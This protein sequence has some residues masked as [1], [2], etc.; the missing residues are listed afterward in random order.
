MSEGEKL[1]LDSGGCWKLQ[2]S[3]PGKNVHLPEHEVRDL[4]HKS[5][6]IFLSQPVLLEICGDIHGQ[7][8]RLL[9]L[10]EYG[11]FP[12]ESDYLRLG[13]YAD[14]GEQSLETT[15]LLLAYKYPENFFLLRGSH[16]RPSIYG[17][18]DDTPASTASTM[19][20]TASTMSESVGPPSTRPPESPPPCSP[21]P[22]HECPSIYGFYGF[23][24]ECA[25]ITPSPPPPHIYTLVPPL[26]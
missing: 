3:R 13:D 2:G 21:H 20:S 14:R 24:D 26:P 18:Y 17:F 8:C 1:S 10:F 12:P 16:E 9:W 22:Y 25:W 19:T 6:G 4:C 5:R 11:G 15:C 7:F 23:Y